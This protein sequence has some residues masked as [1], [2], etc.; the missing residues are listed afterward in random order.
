[1]KNIILQ[2]WTGPLGELEERSKAN[3]EEYAKFCGADYRLIQGNVFRKHLSTPCQKMIMLDSQFDEYDT[4]VM[5]DI[6][7]FTRKGMT[8][9]IFT[10]DTGVGRH[11]GIQP[12][13]RKKLCNRFPLLGDERYP[14]WGGSIYRLEKE[15][16]QQLRVHMIDWE[17][18]HFNNNYEDEGIMHRLAV[19]ADFTEEGAYL[20]DDKWNRSSFE[21]NVSDGYIIHVRRKMKNT[22]GRPSPKQD[23]IINYR[24]LVDKGII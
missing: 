10:D 18:D 15:V 7:M 22:P 23:K 13:L 11:Y 14:Y 1:M 6:D 20:D 3:I 21:E 9:N 19:R 16:R 2:H 12:S 4:V 17:M 5:M 24:N 8:K